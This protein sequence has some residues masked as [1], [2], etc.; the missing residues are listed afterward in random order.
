LLIQYGKCFP[1]IPDLRNL[2]LDRLKPRNVTWTGG[3]LFVCSTVVIIPFQYLPM[4]VCV[5][6]GVAGPAK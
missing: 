5:C 1:E 2:K 6:G 4:C 3:T